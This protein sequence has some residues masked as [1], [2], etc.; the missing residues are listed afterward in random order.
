LVNIVLAALAVASTFFDGS[1]GYQL[2]LLV[3]GGALVGTLIWGF[4]AAER[5]AA[6]PIGKSPPQ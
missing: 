2:A 6:P 5:R 3:V 4:A 1:A